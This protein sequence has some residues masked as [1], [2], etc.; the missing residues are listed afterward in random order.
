M[1]PKFRAGESGSVKC[2]AGAMRLGTGRPG[3]RAQVCSLVKH[4]SRPT[5]A[6]DLGGREDKT[7]G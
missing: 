6:E 4:F 1:N 5:P 3:T 7:T 2:L